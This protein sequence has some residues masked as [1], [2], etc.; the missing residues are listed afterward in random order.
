MIKE[1]GFC[2]S[3]LVGVWLL[4]SSSL[5]LGYAVALELTILISLI[6]SG[7][8]NL[9]RYGKVKW[10]TVANKMGFSVLASLLCFTAYTLKWPPNPF[11]VVSCGCVGLLGKEFILKIVKNTFEK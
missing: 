9:G 7:L 8:D 10:Y 3:Y 4:A 11:V 5:E 2:I 6:C 1:S